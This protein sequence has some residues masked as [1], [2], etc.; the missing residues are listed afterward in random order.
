MPGQPEHAP[1]RDTSGREVTIPID[2]SRVPVPRLLPPCPYEFPDP[3]KATTSETIV[4]HGGDFQPSTVL[5]AYRMG[6]F[7]WPH[8]DAEYVWFSPEPRAILPLDGLRISRRLGRTIRSGRF[9]ATVD[10]AFEQVM[11]ECAVRPDDGTWI[12]PALIDGYTALHVAGHAHS[13]EVWN[14]QGGLAGGLY[15]VAAGAMFGAESMFH[16]ES[17]ASKVAM[18]ALVQLALELGIELIDVQVLT[19][20]TGRMGVVEISRR[21]YLKRLDAA[22]GREAGWS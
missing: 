9:H 21:E 4:A 14:E 11:R 15:G 7:P 3:R 10:V 18:V 20:H 1:L 17:D 13:V 6:M 12:T 5:A 22:L 2:R 16:H 19:D 8:D